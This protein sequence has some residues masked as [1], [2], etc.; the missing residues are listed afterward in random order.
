MPAMAGVLPLPRFRHADFAAFA[1]GPIE[2][3]ACH[4]C[5]AA[6]AVPRK[7]DL[8]TLFDD[9]AYVSRPL[10]VHEIR[11]PGEGRTMPAPAYQASL[12]AAELPPQPAILDVG[13]FDGRLLRAFA[14]IR[15]DAE[16]T[17]FDVS[18]DLA[19]M[20]EGGSASIT[21]VSGQLV[22]HKFTQ[23]FDLIALS[24]SLQYEPDLA[25][26][27]ATLRT[28]L[29]PDG[30]LFIQVPDIERKPSNLLLADLHHHFTRM[31]LHNLLRR[32]GFAPKALAAE[33]FP[34]DILFTARA[35][36]AS[37]G[38]DLAGGYQA[39]ESAIAHLAAQQ[40]RI[41]HVAAE[42]DWHVLGTTIDAAFAATVLGE[43][44]VG[45]VD[46]GC[47]TSGMFHAR[48]VRHPRQLK[49]EDRT[50]LLLGGAGAEILGRFQASYRGLF[51]SV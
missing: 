46:E 3:M 15:P 48:T 44:V 8:R 18:A 31:S 51:V 20:V 24:H 34:R 28:A 19:P 13:C 43:R 49:D 6:G 1:P 14:E 16:L 4:V 9:P 42:N 23:R 22:D 41:E 27:L 45:F 32:S 40:E 29:K 26:L 21:Y 2:I 38:G 30:R 25:G 5:G 11:L 50:L 7:E 39:V 33:G 17:G 10:P 37:S 35:A 36:A 12:L 47:E